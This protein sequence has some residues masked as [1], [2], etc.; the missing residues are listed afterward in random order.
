MPA[1]KDPKFTN[2]KKLVPVPENVL[3]QRKRKQAERKSIAEAQ[4]AR[5]KANVARRKE[6]YRRAEK[7]AQEYR[8]NEKELVHMRRLARSS[9][10]YFVEPE[11][12]VAIVVRLKGIRKVPP[13]VR[14]A[15]RLLRLRQ[16]NNAVFVKLNKATIEMLRLVEQYVAWGYPSLKVVRDLLYKRG[17]V[18]VRG[19]RIPITDNAMI[20]D[21]L[22]KHD[23][24]CLEDMVHQIYT[25]GPKFKQ[26][27]SFL[28]PFKLQPPRHG[29][30]SKKKHFVEGGDLGNREKYINGLLK[31]MI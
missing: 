21:N 23:V 14:K 1:T 7:Y 20:E 3:K 31:R 29:F 8:R 24:I 5:K 4:L 25:V 17:F 9:G 11:A 28:W 26:V 15:L 18:K 16:V 19:D 13:K 10:N 2:I 27:N 12:K 30:R 22:G 6:A